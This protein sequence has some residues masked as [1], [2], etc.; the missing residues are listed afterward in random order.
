MIRVKN[1]QHYKMFILSFVLIEMLLFGIIAWSQ[2]RHIQEYLSDTANSVESKYRIIIKS[3]EDKA[4]I[5]FETLINTDSVKSVFKKAVNS[6][7][8][9]QKE[10]YRNELYELL[11]P[12]YESLKRFNF[13]QIHFHQNNN[14]SFLRMHDP[15]KYGDDLSG[16][17]KTVVYVN[18]THQKISGFEDGISNNGYRFV[19]P[20]FDRNIYL[21]S[22]ELSFSIYTIVN[23]NDDDILNAKFIISKNAL[24]SKHYKNP[25]SIYKTCS[26]DPS[27]VVD[28]NCTDKKLKLPYSSDFHKHFQN[29]P[30]EA[31]SLTK[32]YNNHTYIQTFVP[33]QNPVTS[34]TVAY[35]VTIMDGKYLEQMKNSFHI[36]FISLSMIIILLFM[37]YAKRKEFRKKIQQQNREL[38]LANKRLK[39]II[40]SQNNLIVIVNNDKM[41]EV[42]KKV[43]D[44][45]GFDTFEA[46]IKTNKCIC[47][48]FIKCKECF[49]LDQVPENSSCINYLK[50]LRKK[51]RIV[52][53]ISKDLEVRSFQINIDDYDKNG[54]SIITF[55]DITDILLKQKLL[56][57]KAQHDQ[58]TNIYNRQKTDEVLLN[59]CK[60]SNRRKE[61]IGLI[62]F[63][64]DHFKIVNDQYGHDTG[65]EVLKCIT[66]LVQA[67]IRAEDSFGRWGGEEFILIIRHS[68]L[69]ETI[70]KAENLRKTLEN[71]KAENIPSVTASF[72]VT[73]LKAGDTAKT[74]LKRADIALYKAKKAGRNR[75][76]VEK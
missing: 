9:K 61:K 22:V 74:I 23:H 63:D 60:Y 8:Y 5:A 71:F 27:F 64:I 48:F 46:M 73:E 3:F 62:M 39:T 4:Y 19:F 25:H 20:L 75:V 70:K 7:D 57:Y 10:L 28:R 12:K 16:F 43:L 54:S 66:K 34:K 17:R 76:E 38:S 6:Q 69:Q 31:F 13:R 30:Q 18:Q 52:N 35:I 68:T 32:K 58:L 59:I 21:G 55:N 53:M 33:I 1:I 36:A 14:H 41:I 49:H 24:L 50:S 45:F 42:N 37:R 44:F 65:D 56:E 2:E 26:I 11:S 47:S 67:N 29:N 51:H 40:N 15:Q 72:G